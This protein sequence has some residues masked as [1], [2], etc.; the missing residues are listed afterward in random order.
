MQ[1]EVGW[2][3]PPARRSNCAQQAPCDSSAGSAEPRR[4]AAA[5]N[6]R[7]GDQVIWRLNLRNKLPLH[8]TAPEV[9]AVQADCDRLGC[10]TV[11]HAAQK[12]KR[13]WIGNDITHLAISLI[14]KRR[15]DAFGAKC[16]FVVH[17]T[18]QDLDAARD[19]AARDKY[20]FQYWGRIRALP[21]E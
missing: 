14:E 13:R 3:G 4:Q 9:A 5:E 11:V 7:A 21:P 6:S 8:K 2:D 12:L 16:K 17:G 20:Q 19:L 1:L 18:P 15:K 10:G